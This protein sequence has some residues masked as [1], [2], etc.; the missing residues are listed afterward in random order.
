MK[1]AVR[2]QVADEDHTLASHNVTTAR[3]KTMKR[4]HRNMPRIDRMEKKI[5]ELLKWKHDS[6]RV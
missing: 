5:N 1:N 4:P 6:S 3:S 2:G